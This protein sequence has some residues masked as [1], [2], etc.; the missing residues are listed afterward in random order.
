VGLVTAGGEY[1]SEDL[2]DGDY[3]N[4]AR[5]DSLLEHVRAIVAGAAM[6]DA[7]TR[8]K[9]GT[10]ADKLFAELRNARKRQLLAGERL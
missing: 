4:K 9:I 8:R 10:K 6:F 2:P 7:K 5:F 3:A 1:V